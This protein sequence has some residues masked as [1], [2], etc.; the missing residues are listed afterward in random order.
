MYDFIDVYRKKDEMVI[1][2]DEKIHYKVTEEGISEVNS[3]Y[4]IKHNFELVN[5]D[6][7]FLPDSNLSFTITDKATVDIFKYNNQIFIDIHNSNINR[8]LNY[9]LSLVPTNP[10]D[11]HFQCGLDTDGDI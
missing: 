9:V 6:I 1:G 2:F 5:K 4:P 11:I 7:D 10:Y 8:P 3:K